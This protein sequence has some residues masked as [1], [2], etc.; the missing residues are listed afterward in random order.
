V[1]PQVAIDLGNLKEDSMSDSTL[2]V[3]DVQNDFC[4]PDGLFAKA[5]LDLT[6]VQA[7]VE[8]L[9]PLIH[10]ARTSRIPVIFV[11]TCH[12]A[13]TNSAGFVQRAMRKAARAEIC[14]TGTW[15]A[16]YYRV[17][18]TKEDCEVVKHRY[19]AF[20]GTNL[21]VILRSL[22]RQT[23][24][25]TGVT[26]NVCVESTVRDAYMRDYR[27][28]LVEDCTGAPTRQEY[29]SALYNVRTYFGSVTDSASL[30]RSWSQQLTGT[31]R[32]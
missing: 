8:N 3:V 15:G 31:A 32:Q 23:V 20:V 22:A 16:D 11:K 25:V 27:P 4:H 17:Q 6:G 19:S 9:L 14:A 26:T 29:E 28:V 1:S 5:G 21:E 10:V 30:M 12:D 7:S 18:P 24:V 2:L 13:W